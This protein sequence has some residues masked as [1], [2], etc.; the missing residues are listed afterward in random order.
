M[1][2]G[3]R[4]PWF[5]IVPDAAQ[6]AARRRVGVVIGARD[7]EHGE[8]VAAAGTTSVGGPAVTGTTLFEIGSVTK[9]FTA[10]IL[11]DEVVAGRLTLDTPLRA[12]LPA[13]VLVPVRG[14]EVTLGHLATHHAGLPRAPV[15]TVA[16]SIAMLRGRDPYAGL[17]GDD[18]L[19]VLG[20]T[21]LRRT[22]GTGRTSY[23]NTGGGLLG[24]AL[25]HV[26]GARDYGD[27]VRRRI[28]EP[29]GLGDTRTQ[30][31]L[32][33]DQRARLAQGHRR[34]NRA[35]APWPLDGLPGA[36][37][38]VSTVPDLLRFAA[39]QVDP[40]TTPLAAAMR[41]SQTP[42]RRGIALGWLLAE[43]PEPMLW[44]NGGTGGFRSFLGLLPERRLGV[45]VLTNRA[46]SVDLTALRLLRTLAA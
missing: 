9:V 24:R 1:T 17:V 18:L 10:L 29:L 36:G 11:A 31:E 42:V 15:A 28:C 32:D 3:Q 26:T 2:R 39:A 34:G 43:S 7:P 37:A 20:T 22:P 16:G 12:A 8:I 41:L 44:H 30:R 38:L 35:A 25:V 21:R 46:R 45:V 13:G 6:R 27:L 19:E 5:D 14:A 40:D 23:S 33:S 4:R